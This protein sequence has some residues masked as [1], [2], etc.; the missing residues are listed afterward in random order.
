M[1]LIKPAMLK[2]GDKVAAIS[3]SW[4]GA[5]DPEILWRYEQGKHRLETQF[6][7]EVVEM[8]L[9]LKGSAYVYDRPRERVRDLMQAFLDPSIKGIF[10]CIGGEESIR[11]LPYMDFNVIRKNPKV[12]IGYSDT[13][14]THMICRKAGLSSFYGPAIL[15]DFAENGQMF[16]YTKEWV[17]R[18]LFSNEPMGNVP[19]APIWTSEYLPWLIENKEKMRS[20]QTNTGYEVLQGTGVHS[21]ELIGGC[22]AV[23][24]MIKGTEIWPEI[25]EW[26]NQI[27]FL[28]TSPDQPDPTYV[29][30]W[31]RNYGSQGILHRIK[32]LMFGKPY[33]E[34]YTN[35]YR[36]VIMK[37]VSEELNLK[38]LPIFYNMSFGHTAP[39]CV[40]PYGAMAELD[41]EAK[42]F[43][44]LE[45]GVV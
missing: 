1:K 31:L 4:G 28:E 38:T 14:V 30:Y 10:S 26:D 18:A 13:T 21:G 37:V 11:M 22:M 40:L 35:E 6:G 29:R 3:L 2:A 24:E 33:D 19:A 23:L 41:C 9:T 20:V 17:K 45:S 8:P 12:F 16:D 25:G 42:T 34:K 7:L 43:K 39:M 27:L 32:G 15:S 44:I 36:S 5:G